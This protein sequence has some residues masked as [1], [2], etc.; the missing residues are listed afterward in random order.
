M[1]A[2]SGLLIVVAVVTHIVPRR[3]LSRPGHTDPNHP[4][5]EPPISG[6]MFG[7]DS[8]LSVTQESDGPTVGKGYRLAQTCGTAGPNGLVD[9]GRLQPNCNP[10]GCKGPVQDDT[11]RAS[12]E[13]KGVALPDLEGQSGTRWDRAAEVLNLA[14]LPFPPR[15]H[16]QLL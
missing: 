5:D 2:S 13:V 12:G 16:I 8:S 4:N 14:R 15:P 6:D 7:S 11:A 10:I 1:A 9:G 3:S